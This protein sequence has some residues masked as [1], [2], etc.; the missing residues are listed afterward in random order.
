M[1][2][3]ASRAA[4]GYAVAWSS[5]DRMRTG[6]GSLDTN[7]GA[8][9]GCSQ[10]PAPEAPPAIEGGSPSPGRHSLRSIRNEGKPTGCSVG[11]GVKRHP[12]AF[13]QFGASGSRQHGDRLAGGSL[14]CLLT[15]TADEV[16]G[17]SMAASPDNRRFASN[18][19]TG[20]HR[21][22][23]S[24]G[25]SSG[26]ARPRPVRHAGR[27]QGS[28]VQPGQEWVACA[29]AG[30]GEAGW[31]PVDAHTRKT[32][33]PLP[34]RSHRRGCPPARGPSFSGGRAGTP[35]ATEANLTEAGRNP[36][37]PDDMSVSSI[38]RRNRMIARPSHGA[39]AGS[40]T[41]CV[42]HPLRSR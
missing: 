29:I 39:C 41:A 9:G 36:A 31:N 40:Q 42:H 37:K 17:R 2:P 33:L 20:R 38:V 6:S 1:L 23:T 35:V 30:P 4:R 15:A 5:C 7:A 34:L 19:K 25:P 21:T 10:A 28:Q 3:V 22:G 24:V 16:V 32:I 11:V 26:P 27:Q 13:S 18:P 14:R 8:A 12:P